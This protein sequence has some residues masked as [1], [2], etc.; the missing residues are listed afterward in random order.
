MKQNAR[1]GRTY[2]LVQTKTP[3]KRHNILAAMAAMLLFISPTGLEKEV[4]VNTDE[5][6]MDAIKLNAGSVMVY[7]WYEDTAYFVSHGKTVAAWYDGG[8]KFTEDWNC[9]LP[10]LVSEPYDDWGAIV[11]KSA[12]SVPVYRKTVIKK[13]PDISTIEVVKPK[14]AEEVIVDRTKQ[15]RYVRRFAQTARLE[16]EKFGV[17][18]SIKLAQ[19]ILESAAGESLLA[20]TANNHFGIKCR[21]SKVANGCSDKYYDKMEKSNAR[22]TSYDYPDDSFRDHSY[23]LT[24]ERYGHLVKKCD[25]DYKCWA[26]GLKAAGYATDKRYA[27]KLI[28]LIE[29]LELYKYDK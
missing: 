29:T 25:G 19:G 5:L 27:G 18:A 22:Y 7:G 26:K 13:S 11:A 15:Y 23:L 4:A 20:V 24:N 9:D 14:T 2:R 16:M 21:T 17:P 3:T 10:E 6:V 28:N 1:I 8:V 12:L